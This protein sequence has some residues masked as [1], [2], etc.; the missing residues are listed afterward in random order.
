MVKSAGRLSL[1]KNQKN[2]LSSNGNNA[3]D[4]P[5]L[6]HYAYKSYESLVE[7]VGCESSSA[8]LAAW[9]Y[10]SC[11]DY[12]PQEGGVIW[13]LFHRKFINLTLKHCEIYENTANLSARSCFDFSELMEN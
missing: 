13:L 2:S 1:P 8:D 12:L 6:I 3:K 4:N 5:D 9:L 7:S 10:A 11:T